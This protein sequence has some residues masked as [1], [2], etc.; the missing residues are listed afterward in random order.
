MDHFTQ[1]VW[2][3]S[4]FWIGVSTLQQIF[5]HP[6]FLFT[7]YFIIIINI[8]TSIL[9][10]VAY[11]RQ[12]PNYLFGFHICINKRITTPF[13]F[14]YFVSSW[15]TILII[16]FGICCK[17]TSVFLL[18]RLKLLYICKDLKNKVIKVNFYQQ[19]FYATTFAYKCP[20]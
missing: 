6:L 15:K 19:I 2:A 1:T 4:C 17:A 18:I 9:L 10:M 16:N 12:R 3:R 5:P 14:C 7:L 11:I 13:L 20:N 8:F